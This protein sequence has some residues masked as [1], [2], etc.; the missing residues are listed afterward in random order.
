MAPC[1]WCAMPAPKPAAS[2]VRILAAA[3]SN[4]GSPR[5]RRPKACSAAMPAAAA[6]PARTARSCWIAWKAPMGRPN[7][8]RSVDV[9]D[10]LLE[11]RLERARHLRRAHHGAVQPSPRA[12][13]RRAGRRGADDRGVVEDQRVAGLQREVAIG[14]TWAASRATSATIGCPSAS[15]STTTW[16]ARRTPG[17]AGT[18]VPL[19]LPAVARAGQASRSSSRTAPA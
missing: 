16:P 5:S 13:C 14:V 15:P 9:A 18:R 11:Q 7:C 10:R 3:I 17:H 6:W 1:A 19:E 4:S 2:P 12:R 8:L